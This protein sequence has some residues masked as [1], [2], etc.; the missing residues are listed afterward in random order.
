MLQY[1]SLNPGCFD[2]P[3]KFPYNELRRIAKLLGVG[4]S[5]KREEIVQRLRKWHKE[6]A[7]NREVGPRSLVKLSEIHL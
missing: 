3:T 6:H 7:D 2:S 5:G 4:G 1:V